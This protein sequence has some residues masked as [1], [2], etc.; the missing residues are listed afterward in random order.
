VN[1]GGFGILGEPSDVAVH[2]VEDQIALVLNRD[3]N[4]VG[5]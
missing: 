2:P 4:A 1:V 5:A 3:W